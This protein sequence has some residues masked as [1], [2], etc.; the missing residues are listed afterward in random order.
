MPALVLLCI[1]Q[2]LRQQQ[3]P[4]L[5]FLLFLLPCC[6]HMTVLLS[7]LFAHLGL[8]AASSLACLRRMLKC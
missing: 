3:A 7:A 4:W 5:Q 8:E 6:L 1:A 2:G